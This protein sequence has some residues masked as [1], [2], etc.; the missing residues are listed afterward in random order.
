MKKI[1][2]F[3][4]TALM[5]VENEEDAIDAVIILHDKIANQKHS[6]DEL[7]RQNKILREALE[8]AANYVREGNWQKSDMLHLLNRILK[9]ALKSTKENI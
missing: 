1:A 6:I 7:T 3:V 8:E 2:R 9:P 5:G 4:A